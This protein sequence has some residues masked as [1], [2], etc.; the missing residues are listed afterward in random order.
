MRCVTKCSLENVVILC[1]AMN[2]STKIVI[3]SAAD[4][5]R[6]GELRSLPLAALLKQNRAAASG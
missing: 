2:G 3:V 6:Y 5:Q 4:S 1:L